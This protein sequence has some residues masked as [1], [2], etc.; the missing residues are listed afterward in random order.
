MSL[1]TWIAF[2]DIVVINFLGG[3]ID[4]IIHNREKKNLFTF[5][6]QVGGG[7]GGGGGWS[8]N[9]FLGKYLIYIPFSL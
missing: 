2:N 4:F 5:F 1:T 7:G 8:T 9:R 6:I 3:Q